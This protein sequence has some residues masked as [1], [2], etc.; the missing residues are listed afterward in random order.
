M[1]ESR[2]RVP[3]RTSRSS[4]DLA[5]SRREC[6]SRGMRMSCWWFKERGET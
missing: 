6:G 4:G 5:R 3:L 1:A 2:V